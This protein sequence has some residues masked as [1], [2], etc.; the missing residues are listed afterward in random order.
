MIQFFR[1]TI[2]EGD[3][4]EENM[5]SAIQTAIP[6]AIR[7]YKE[8]IR[9][10]ATIDHIEQRFIFR[11]PG[12]RRWLT[13]QPDLVGTDSIGRLVVIDYKT[14]SALDLRRKAEEFYSRITMP[15]YAHAVQHGYKLN[16]PQ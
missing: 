12:T 13:C 11:I 10:L 2:L 14:T 9:N 4:T 1:D 5:T 7:I 6:T 3:I 16:H 8:T 15:L